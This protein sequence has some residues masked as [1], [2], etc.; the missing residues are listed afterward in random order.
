MTALEVEALSLT[1]QGER[2]LSDISFTLRPGEFLGLLGPNGAGK[3]TLLRALQG[4]LPHEGRSSLAQIS[5]EA[6]ARRAAFLPQARDLAWPMAVRDLVALGRLP[7]TG[8]ARSDDHRAV[9][10]ALT[11]MELEALA[12]RPADRLSGG[13]LARALIARLLA[14]ETPLLLA[15]E[16]G[17]GLDPARQISTMQVFADLARE[18]RAVVASVHDLGLAARFCTRVLVLQEGRLVADGPPAEVLSDSLL[19]QVFGLR[20]WRGEAGGLPLL[21]PIALT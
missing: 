4:L 14:Q 2:V 16:P 8:A 18:G 21:A 19:D 6:R 17:A 12:D 7:W 9:A 11:R 3:T 1:R 5:A 10:A 20:V 13:E 15:D